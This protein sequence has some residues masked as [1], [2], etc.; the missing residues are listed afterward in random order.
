M[1]IF[2]R[3]KEHH[4][5]GFDCECVTEK[6]HRQPVALVQLSTIDGY[7]GLFRLNK[8]KSIPEPLKVSIV[9]NP[10]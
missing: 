5:I 1:Y 9:G 4:A 3:C 7:C 8:I 2:S 10:W 6:G